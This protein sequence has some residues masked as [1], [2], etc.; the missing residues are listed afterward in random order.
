MKKNIYKGGTLTNIPDIIADNYSS[1]EYEPDNEIDDKKELKEK[2]KQYQEKFN[3]WTEDDDVDD[4]V[5][6]FQD[7][8]GV[9]PEVNNST[10]TSSLTFDNTGVESKINYNIIN[11]LQILKDKLD[12]LL[13]IQDYKS[14][15][16]FFGKH[17]MH[18]LEAL[19]EYLLEEFNETISTNKKM[20]FFRKIIKLSIDAMKKLHENIKTIKKEDTIST[21]LYRAWRRINQ[22]K[23]MLQNASEIDGEQEI[24]TDNFLSTTRELDKALTF[25]K[26]HNNGS[27]NADDFIVWKITFNKDHHHS[28]SA[29]VNGELSE[30]ILD[31]CS[32]LILKETKKHNSNGKLYTMKTFLY[33]GSGS[34][35][36]IFD[37]YDEIIPTIDLVVA[38]IE[39]I[40]SIGA[41][42]FDLEEKKQDLEKKKEDLK[43]KKYK[44]LS[45]NLKLPDDSIDK[46]ISDEE[47]QKGGKGRKTQKKKEIMGQIRCIYKKP[48]DRKEYVKYKGELVTIKEFK[49]IINTNKK[50]KKTPKASKK[51]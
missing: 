3:E 8:S 46:L 30:V 37:K 24:V 38:K 19:V 15:K 42:N 36:E 33:N 16:E 4:F 26:I 34:D 13:T 28:N 22:E 23:N 11:N 40:S 35:K 44:Y 27:I 20:L 43:R 1:L 12:E 48:K 6:N 49:K 10:L 45:S 51:T 21:T 2:I 32:K 41:E 25:Y 31:I 50:T 7:D 18:Y 9:N 29:I 5:A 17:K 39:L 14:L 47:S